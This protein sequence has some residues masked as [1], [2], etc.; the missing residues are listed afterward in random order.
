[1]RKTVAEVAAAIATSIQ[2]D[3]AAG[4]DP[5]GLQ[6][7]DPRAVVHQVAV[8]YE[9]TPEI[10]RRL[11]DAKV[12]MVIS[13]HPLLFR[14][15]AKL[16]S[17]PG[18]AGRAHDHI[19]NGIALTVV[20]TAFDVM[21]GGTADALAAALGLVDVTGFGPA[22]TRDV[23]KIVTFAPQES[24]DHVA[25]AMATAGAGTIG[26]YSNCSFRTEGTGVFHPLG[27]ATPHVG[28]TDRVNHEP[29]VRIEMIAPETAVDAVVAA[30]VRS[31]PYEEPAYDV[32]TT[33]SNAGFVGRHGKLDVA[34][35][36]KDLADRVSDRLGGTARVAGSGI[37]RTVAVVPGS[38]GSFLAQSEADAVVTGDVSHHQARAATASG[39]AVIDP[40]HA[41]TERPGVQALYA[42]IAETIDAIDMTD[43]DQ[44][45]WKER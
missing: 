14:P 28:A 24:A 15:V 16:V 19:A 20:H 6:L 29:E 9:V 30:L 8:C 34:M 44:D 39:I 11:V 35:N 40:G 18:P 23:V 31:H 21:A 43:I 27:S 41:P 26:E 3:K 5:V 10:V 13:Y 7:G 17:G 38:G 32:V 4:W 1:M 45:P 2:F 36:V 25:N 33:R 37:I 42:L 22:W 12:D